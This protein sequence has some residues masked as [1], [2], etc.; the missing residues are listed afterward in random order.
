METYADL[1][2]ILNFINFWEASKERKILTKRKEIWLFVE[3]Q[4][5]WFVTL[6][7]VSISHNENPIV[8]NDCF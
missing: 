2:A 6:N 1:Q 8:V 3:D 7:Q 4:L 5:K